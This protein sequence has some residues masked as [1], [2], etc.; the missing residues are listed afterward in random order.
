MQKMKKIC[1][2]YKRDLNFHPS[3]IL[4]K[5]MNLVWELFSPFSGTTFLS[6]MQVIE[7]HP[8]TPSNPSTLDKDSFSYKTHLTKGSPTLNPLISIDVPPY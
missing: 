4:Y 5:I 7:P 6:E 3:F 1:H 2:C 8:G